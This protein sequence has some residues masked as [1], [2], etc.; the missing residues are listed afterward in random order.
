[1]RKRLYRLISLSSYGFLVLFVLTIAGCQ[2][3]SSKKESGIK[4]QIDR[5]EDDLFS[6][7][8]YNMA[9]SIDF[10]RQKY[11][12][13]F[14][15]FTSKII[16]IGNSDAE[17]ISTGLIAFV[18]D[19][20]IYRADKRVKEVFPS[21]V[22]LE[23]E[24]TGVFGRYQLDFPEKQ[25]PH[26]VTCISGFNQ[27]IITADSLLVISLEKYLGS[28]DEFYTLLY[29]P[30]PEYLRQVM[31]PE[32]ISP[33]V[34]LAW[35]ITEFQY[36]PQTDN[37]LSQMIYYGRAL[38]YVHRL[39][40]E[41]HDTLLWGYTSRQMDF[42]YDYEKRMWE[43][44]VENKK[45][46]ITDGFGI[47]QFIMDAPFTK[48]FTQES[49]GR[50]AIWLGYRIVDSYMK[51]NRDVSIRDLLHETDYQKILNVSKYNP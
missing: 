25:V 16:E 29:P 35:F 10:L 39:I 31:R 11:P 12:D 26:I 17:D 47:N 4:I 8:L 20:T 46:F 45:L 14:P 7:S 32:R 50:A 19:F 34:M 9:D 38:Y 15:L 36:N 51:K 13:F 48:D 40:P 2:R 24:L 27:S 28:D 30:V 23:R 1:M 3:S 21:L 37:L 33:D 42:C 41:V 22:N 49:P 44:L 18:S 5:F 43:Y 6:I